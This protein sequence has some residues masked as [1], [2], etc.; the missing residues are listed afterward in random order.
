MD[1]TLD[2]VLAWLPVHIAAD[3]DCVGGPHEW[4]EV[5][6]GGVMAGTTYTF[7][8]RC[9]RKKRISSW[10]DTPGRSGITAG[11]PSA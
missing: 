5:A 9:P 8:K 10:P 2:Q 4:L 1:V 3:F 11:W 6:S 7:C